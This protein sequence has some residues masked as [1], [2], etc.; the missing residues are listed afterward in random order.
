M[1]VDDVDVLGYE[2]AQVLIMGGGDEGGKKGEVKGAED[3]DRGSDA[4]GGQGGG[5]DESS[6]KETAED[7][8]SRLEEE[9]H[10]RVQHLEHDDPIFA[11]LG[12]SSKEYTEMQTTW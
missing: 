4:D 9:D 2:G 11:D 7:E 8:I 5:E 3:A 1:D 6:G 10:D 12:L